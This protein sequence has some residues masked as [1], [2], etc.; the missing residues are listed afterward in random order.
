[1]P[2]KEKTPKTPHEKALKCLGVAAALIREVAAA[3]DRG[4]WNTVFRPLEA[5]LNDALDAIPWEE[6]PQLSL[7][8][9][10]EQESR[11]RLDLLLAHVER[12]E[13]NEESCVRLISKL[14]SSLI[15]HHSDVAARHG[16]PAFLEHFKLVSLWRAYPSLVREVKAATAAAEELKEKYHR[17]GRGTA[18]QEAKKAAS[19]EFREATSA[20]EKLQIDVNAARQSLSDAQLDETKCLAREAFPRSPPEALGATPLHAASGSS[21]AGKPAEQNKEDAAYDEEQRKETDCKGKEVSRKS[22]VRTEAARPE[23]SPEADAKKAAEKAA[24]AAAQAKA[25][26]EAEAAAKVLAETKAKEELMAVFKEI[27]PL[28][29]LARADYDTTQALLKKLGQ[30]AKV[31]KG[32][33]SDV[34][35][36]EL[37]GTEQMKQLTDEFNCNANDMWSEIISMAG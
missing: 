11:V 9:Q 6:E 10:E 13:Q 35:L 23:E 17:I 36:T 20:A 29:E 25:A 19:D 31:V 37:A 1:M 28:G 32:T 24:T 26:A 22:S 34:E 4:D 3:N 18:Y 33:L 15:E 7:G 16:V 30:A 8:Q 2:P 5:A 27:F 21:K 14:K 12:A